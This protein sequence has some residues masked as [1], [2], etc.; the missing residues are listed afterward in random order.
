[1]P[2]GRRRRRIHAPESI[3]FRLWDTYEALVL[4]VARGALVLE[5]LFDAMAAVVSR[6][7]QLDHVDID[8]LVPEAG[9]PAVQ[10]ALMTLGY[11]LTE[12]SRLVP[13]SRR[14]RPTTCGPPPGCASTSATILWSCPDAPIALPT[15]PSNGGRQVPIRKAAAF[16]LRSASNSTTTFMPMRSS[17]SWSLLC[18]VEKPTIG[19]L[20]DGTLSQTASTANSPLRWNWRRNPVRLQCYG[21]RSEWC[22]RIGGCLLR[23]RILTFLPCLVAG[24]SQSRWQPDHP[25][26]PRGSHRLPGWRSM[27]LSA[28]HAHRNM[29]GSGVVPSCTWLRWAY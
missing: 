29:L 24:A 10:T 28:P 20:S 18:G 8:V 6:P 9:A 27:P 11:S 12:R 17:I 2:T 21:Q 14:Q 15:I 4:R 23:R 1:M 5:R 19:M 25:Q 22:T 3:L 16:T 7:V 13:A 26:L